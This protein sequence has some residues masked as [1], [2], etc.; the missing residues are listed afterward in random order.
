MANQPRDSN[1][2]KNSAGDLEG[3]GK[4]LVPRRPRRSSSCLSATHGTPEIF[5]FRVFF[6]N[7]LHSFQLTSYHSL[8]LLVSVSE[9]KY[10]EPSTA[11]SAEPTAQ[12]RSSLKVKGFLA[13]RC[14]CSDSIFELQ[15]NSCAPSGPPFSSLFPPSPCYFTR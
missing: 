13:A 8:F 5:V 2:V 12:P 6:E 7:D 3:K 10:Q 1:T 15:T 9:M 14:C 11:V 4:H